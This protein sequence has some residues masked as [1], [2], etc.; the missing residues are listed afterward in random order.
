MM[1]LQNT[2]INTGKPENKSARDSIVH[3][4]VHGF[5]TA[6]VWVL[7]IGLAVV[8]LALVTGPY[9]WAVT[10]RGWVSDGAKATAGGSQGGRRPGPGRADRA[11]VARAPGPDADAGGVLAVLLLLVLSVSWIGLLVILALLG[12]YEFWLYRIGAGTRT[13]ATTEAGRSA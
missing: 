10:S 6:S 5:F 8:A 12:A 2:L 11:L 7:G 1:W 13:A 9:R 4:L 3:Q